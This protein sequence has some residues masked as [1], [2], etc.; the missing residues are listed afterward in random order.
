V[1]FF[2]TGLSDASTFFAGFASLLPLMIGLGFFVFLISAGARASA[3]VE[4][5][6][7]LDFLALAGAASSVAFAHS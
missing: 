5:A 3:T 4:S 1:A 7:V 2:S 6:G